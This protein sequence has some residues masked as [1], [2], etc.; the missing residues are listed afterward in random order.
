MTIAYTTVDAA[1]SE[2]INYIL[3]KYDILFTEVYISNIH[4]RERIYAPVCS[5]LN[6]NKHGMV[7]LVYHYPTSNLK[8]S[9]NSV[10]V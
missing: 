5:F 6:S 1:V 10:T 4:I 9:A 7:S 2:T 8:I 3:P